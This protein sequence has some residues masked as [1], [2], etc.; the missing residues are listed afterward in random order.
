[1]YERHILGKNGEEAAEEYLKKKGYNIIERNFRSKVGEI[2]IIA[3]DENYI[4]FIEIK[5]RSNVEY[6][7][8]SEAVTERKIKHIYRTAQYFLYSR[9]LE[10]ENARIDVIEVYNKNNQYHINHLKQV[11]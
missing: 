11:V 4:V 8:P 9:N 10:N 1:M 7:L 3:L 6:G 5:T 2:D